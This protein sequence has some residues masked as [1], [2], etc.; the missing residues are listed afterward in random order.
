[1]STAPRLALTFDDQYI[2][3]WLAAADILK[4]HHACATFFVMGFP[5]IPSLTAMKL[6]KLLDKGH[7][8]G[9]HSV[10]HINAVEAI[11]TNSIDAYIQAEITPGLEGMKMLGFTPT[12][13]AY[14]FNAHTPELDAALKPMF[15]VLR[16]RANTLQDALAWDRTKPILKARSCDTVRADGQTLRAVDDTVH[17]LQLTARAGKSIALYA[18]GVSDKPVSHHHMTSRGLDYLLW[19]AKRLGFT[20]VRA[21]DFDATRP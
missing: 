3:E 13:F 12:S 21:S 20:F 15:S 1:M 6:H 14:P 11:K 4:A 16:A 10:S 7:E 8:I 19:S 9:F 17:E 2:D 18:H 5:D